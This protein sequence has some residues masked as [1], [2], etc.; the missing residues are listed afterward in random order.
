MNN[1][2]SIVF[3][4]LILSCSHEL[5]NQ[6]T[7][8]EVISNVGPKKDPNIRKTQCTTEKVITTYEVGDIPCA[9]N[10]M[11]VGNNEELKIHF[12]VTNKNSNDIYEYGYQELLR[13]RN[14][15]IVERMK[16]RNDEDAYW[17]E[18]PFVR[19]RKQKYVSDI[20]GDGDFEFAIFPFH[21]GSAIWGTVRIFSLKEKIEFFGNG[22]YQFEGDTFVQFGCM[23]CSKFNPE[24]CNKCY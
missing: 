3:F 15:K 11:R 9:R 23:S 10:L 7:E 24:A 13:F 14:G 5:I 16:L 19:I 2:S 18:V 6:R 1:L 4:L 17:S 21:P 12:K 20:D 8:E 22:R